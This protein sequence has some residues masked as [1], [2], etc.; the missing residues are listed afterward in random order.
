VVLNK[1]DIEREQPY[2][3]YYSYS[4]PYYGYPSNSGGNGR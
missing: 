4:S 3:Y 1:V 2:Y